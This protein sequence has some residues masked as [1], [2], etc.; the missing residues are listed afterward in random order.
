MGRGP[1]P[2]GGTAMRI[3]ALNWKDPQHPAA[4]GAEVYTREVVRHLVAAGHDVVWFASAVA[5]LPSRAS[6]AGAEVVRDGGQLGVYRAARRWWRAEGRHRGFDVVVDE[7]NTRP[8]HAPRWADVPVVALIHQPAAEVWHAELGPLLGRLGSHVIEPWWLRGYRQVPTVTVSPSSRA[9]LEAM[10][11]QRVTCLPQGTDPRP[12]PLPRPSLAPPAAGPVLVWCGRLA[13]NKRPDHAI[14]AFATIV[15]RHPDAS[16]W[17]I[18]DGPLRTRL[19]RRAAAVPGVR[20]FGH[21]PAATRDALL[22]GAD[23]LVTTSVREGWGLNVSE[24]ALLG[25]PTVGY[26]VGGLV[27]SVPASGG[28]LTDPDPGALAAGVDAVLSGRVRLRPRPS[29]VPWRDVAA[30]FETVLRAAVIEAGTGRVPA[31]AGPGR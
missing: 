11:L 20:L 7:V 9:A 8:F 27:D 31:R 26:R 19:E 28:L 23:L 29:T 5:G 14:E 2:A 3:C 24:A 22:A 18:G 30:R 17:I 1:A 4:G 25:T 16:L 12:C 6:V 13:K 10:G 21:V 15:R